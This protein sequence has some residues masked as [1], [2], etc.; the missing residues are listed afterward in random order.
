VPAARTGI[1]GLGDD[2]RDQRALVGESN[3]VYARALGVLE[4]LVD[5]ADAD[6]AILGRI[7]EAWAARSFRAFYER[8]L[9]LLASMRADALREGTKHPL[10]SSFA[11]DHPD[12]SAVDRSAIARGLAP[13]WRVWSHLRA[14]RVQ[15]NDVSRAIAWRWP[16]LAIGDRPILLVDVGCAAGLNLVADSLPAPWRDIGGSKL[17]IATKVRAVSRVGFDAEPIDVRHSDEAEWLR[18]CIWPGD[19]TRLDR[20]E[21]AIDAMVAAWGRP[22]APR[23]EPVKAAQVPAR[24]ASLEKTLAPGGVVL[25]YQSFLREYLDPVEAHTYT[26]G[27]EQWLASL[28]RGRAMWSELELM[29]KSGEHPA[30]L[31]ARVSGSPSPLLLA[32]CG[33]HPTA[34]DLDEAGTTA[35]RDH[36]R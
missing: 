7:R 35:L 28:P 18:A 23:L 13:Q 9:L 14:R 27:M 15:T 4:S 3:A 2:I 26:A 31:T 25:V 12:V 32:R 1:D 5:G 22:G 33:Y 16:A 34:V 21:E 20:L 10:A 29:E 11:S 19:H 36:W 24:L 30:A 8:P 6:P 17:E